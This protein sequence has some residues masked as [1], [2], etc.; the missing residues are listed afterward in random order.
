M[1]SLNY[2][3]NDQHTTLYHRSKIFWTQYSRCG[4]TR[5]EW[6]GRGMVASLDL[7]LAILLL[8]HPRI[9]HAFL[10]TNV[11]YWLM[12]NLLSTRTQVG[13]SFPVDQP[14]TCT[15]CCMCLFLPSCRTLYLPLLNLIK[16][17]S[18]QLSFWVSLGLVEW[19][20]SLLILKLFSKAPF[21]GC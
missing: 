8:M 9:T 5:A 3:W 10:A 11:H 15:V 1:H 14:Q 6:R 19:Q 21:C 4:L 20:L 16:F 17:L 7:L 18:T 12:V 2:L 13:C